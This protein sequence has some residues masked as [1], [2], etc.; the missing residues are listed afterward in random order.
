MGGVPPSA[1]LRGCLL[2]GLS[3]PPLL[4]PAAAL[5]P[6][7]SS[8]GGGCSLQGP[9]PPCQGTPPYPGACRFL[10]SGPLSPIPPRKDLQLVSTQAVTCNHSRG[11]AEGGASSLTTLSRL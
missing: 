8:W 10:S 6:L 3:P 4:S 11:H 1:L 2:S 5:P 9:L 7:S